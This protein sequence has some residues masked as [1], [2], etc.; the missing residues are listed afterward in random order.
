VATGNLS[1]LNGFKE[2]IEGFT[3]TKNPSYRLQIAGAGALQDKVAEAAKSD[4][5]IE[6]L[7]QLPFVEVL[8]LYKSADCLICMRLTKR[9]DSRYFFPSKLFEYLASGVPVITTRTGHVESEYQNIAVLLYEE[10]AEALAHKMDE[11]AQLPLET[12]RT[13]GKAAAQYMRENATWD[14]VGENVAEYIVR[15]LGSDSGE[16]GIR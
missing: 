11:V 1:E 9:V 16:I 6:Y 13:L 5:R 3:Q 7:G 2:I 8:E 12:R 15:L 4:P 10:T 14:K